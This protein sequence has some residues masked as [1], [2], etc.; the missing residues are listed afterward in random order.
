V[1]NDITGCY[2]LVSFDIIVNPLPDVVGITDFIL[3]ELNTDGVDEFDLTLKDAEVLNGQDPTEF[4][5]T[6]HA[7]QEDADDLMNSLVS[8]Y[9]NT[10]NPQQ[11]FIAITNNATGCSIS[12][13]S[14]NIEVQEAAEANSDMDAIL[15]IICDDQM[16]DDNDLTN[17]SAQFDLTPVSD[18]LDLD[19]SSVQ[20]Q[21]LDGQ[22]PSNYIVSYYA[23]ESDAE[24]GVNPL[25]FL[26][27]NIINPQV[28]YVRVDNDTPDGM[29]MDTSICY[30][31]APLTLQVDPLPVFDLDDRYILCVGTNGTE[32]LNAPILDTGL[33][34]VDYGFTWL[35]N[36]VEIPGATQSSYM[37]TAGGTYGVIVEHLLTLCS[38]EDTTDVIESGP[39]E[40]TVAVTTDA[41]ADSHTI[42][43]SVTGDIT[44]YEYS[45]D[46]GPWQEEPI[47]TD[48]SIGEHEV[49]VRDKDGCGLASDKVTVMDY[50]TFFTPNG[51]GYND[52]WNISMP[53]NVRLST[54]IYIFDRY[55]KLL[56]QISPLGEGWNGTYNGA[57]MPTSDYWFVVEYSEPSTLQQKEFKSHFTLKR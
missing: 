14:F 3:C 31:V 11:I 19:P 13:P 9:N 43:V 48:V 54:K 6:Y 8:P 27:E 45:L 17:N 35:F 2:T 7:S 25:P 5:V 53:E 29:G 52:T 34:T 37:P 30:A 40:F 23:S 16:D 10:S 32:V 42:E 56:K 44:E 38:S 39:P 51:D 20:A 28:I 1:T 49:S 36:G 4:T 50:P 12:T 47:F 15:E 57:P 21:V 41:F 26:Y 46:G 18:V 24:L 22:D 33:S 55:G